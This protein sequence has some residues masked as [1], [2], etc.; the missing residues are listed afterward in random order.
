MSLQIGELVSLMAATGVRAG[1]FPSKVEGRVSLMA[2]NNS[3][4]DSWNV[5]ALP[6]MYSIAVTVII[7]FVTK[8]P[9]T[10][11]TDVTESRERSLVGGIGLWESET[12]SRD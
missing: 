5:L 10:V 8:M 1:V 9:A 3:K 12:R 7:G 6:L 4:G 11:T 2:E